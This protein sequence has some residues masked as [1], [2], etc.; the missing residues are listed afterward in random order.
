MFPFMNHDK[1]TKCFL[2]IANSL[3]ITCKHNKTFRK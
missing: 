1:G 2:I 3:I